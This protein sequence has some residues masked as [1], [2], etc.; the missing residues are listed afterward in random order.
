[1]SVFKN[2]FVNNLHM[3]YVPFYFNALAP[4]LLFKRPEKACSAFNLFRRQLSKKKK[5]DSPRSPN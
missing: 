4:F 1:M 3:L 5:K 2:D